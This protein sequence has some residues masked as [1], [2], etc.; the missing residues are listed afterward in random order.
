M[1]DLTNCVRVARDGPR[2]WHWIDRA[3]FDP[4]T[5]VDLDAP[6]PEAELPTGE[7]PEPFDPAPAKVEELKTWLTAAEV[8]IPEGALKADL[9]AL[10]TAKLAE[11]AE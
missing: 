7:A 4:E 1:T 11:L 3:K 8:E 10:A 2:G 6:E 9:Q 5:M